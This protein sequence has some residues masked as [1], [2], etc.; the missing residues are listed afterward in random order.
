MKKEILAIIPA[1]AD[2]KSIPKKNIK[3]L[4]GKPLIQYTIDAAKKSKLITRAILSSD[5]IEIIN[6]CKR[7]G[8]EAPFIRPKNLSGDEI[9]MLD[10]IK[11]AVAYLKAYEGY[12]PD[13]I[14]LLQPTSPLRKH[15]DID[16]ALKLLINSNA[17]SVVSVTQVPHSYSPYSVMKLE[18]R[19]LTSF[20][21]GNE[22]N[23]L[24]QKK[25]KFYARNGPAI[26]AFTYRCFVNMNSMYG[27]KILPYFMTKE[28]SVDIDDKFDFK[29][30]EFIIKKIF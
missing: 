4:A 27:K 6:Y 20:M 21:R 10:V 23:N 7:N 14:V 17:D 22:R 24:R 3:V 13:Y 1:R 26:L 28:K 29:V 8:I 9:P 16:R 2:S 5:S 12:I 30:A 19:Y 18:G 15:E 11:H 25:P